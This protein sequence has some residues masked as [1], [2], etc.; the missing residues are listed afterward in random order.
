MQYQNTPPTVRTRSCYVTIP[1]G[2]TPEIPTA[3]AR[4]SISWHINLSDLMEPREVKIFHV[5]EETLA[6]WRARHV[7]P[8]YVT[9]PLAKGSPVYYPRLKWFSP[10]TNATI[11]NPSILLLLRNRPSG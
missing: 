6:E 8:P 11:D 7:G 4:I 10:G 2:D 1:M 5:T 9:F 3:S